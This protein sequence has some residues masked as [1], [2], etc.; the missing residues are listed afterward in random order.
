MLYQIIKWIHIL[1]AITALGANITYE[2]WISR[3]T[4]KPEVLPFTLRTVKLIDDWLANPAYVLLLI[5]GFLMVWITKFPLTT[6]WLLTS[7]VLYALLALMGLLIYT[8]TLKRQIELAQEVGPSSPVY[9]QIARRATIVGAAL[10]VFAV[11]I[12][13]LMVVKPPLWA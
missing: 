10:A 8:P 11:A 3:A 13:F 9:L 1:S 6:P 4:K 12:V 2:V 5:T 7:L